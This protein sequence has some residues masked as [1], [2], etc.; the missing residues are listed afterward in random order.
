MKINVGQKFL[1]KF[2]IKL[3]VN[4]AY[5]FLGLILKNKKVQIEKNKLKNV[6][7][8]QKRKKFIITAQVLE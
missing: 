3:K 4:I 7:S 5:K 2:F 6:S 8:F 1:L